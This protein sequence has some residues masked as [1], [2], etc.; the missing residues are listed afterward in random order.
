MSQTHTPGIPD[1]LEFDPENRNSNKPGYGILTDY[2]TRI[3]VEGCE[4][5]AIA[6]SKEVVRRWNAHDDLVAAL[7]ALLEN[8]LGPQVDDGAEWDA[9]CDMAKAALAKAGEK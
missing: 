3:H 7:R 8:N 9:C 6:L 4:D 1:R 5:D 2:G